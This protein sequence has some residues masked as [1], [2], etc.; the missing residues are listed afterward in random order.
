MGFGDLSHPENHEG[1]A[2]TPLRKGFYE[3]GLMVD[4]LLKFG[5]SSYGVGFYYRY[6]PYAFP[7]QSDNF[8]VKMTVGYAF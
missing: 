8:V 7:Q 5:F 2:F 6:G 3:S 1:L 4:N